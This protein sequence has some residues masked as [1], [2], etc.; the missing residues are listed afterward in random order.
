MQDVASE[1]RDK[2]CDLGVLSEIVSL[3]TEDN[4]C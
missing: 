3:G 4:G 1:E 2:E